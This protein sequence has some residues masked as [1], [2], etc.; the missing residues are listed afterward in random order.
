MIGG[1]KWRD[2]TSADLRVG[3]TLRSQGGQQWKV[4][5]IEDSA[6]G[7]KPVV[8]L[9]EVRSMYAGRMPALEIQRWDCNLKVDKFVCEEDVH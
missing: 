2:V 4:L 1:G 8:T 5:A 9:K 3:M 6:N 7:P